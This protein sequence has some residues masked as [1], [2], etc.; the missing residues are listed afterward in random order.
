M[1][2]QNSIKTTIQTL[3]NQAGVYQYFDKNDKLLC[4]GKAKNL[5]NR[6]KS[7]W[8]FTPELHPNPKLGLRILRMLQQ[9]VRLEYIVVESEADALIL[10]NSLIKQLNPKYNILLRDDK[11]YPYIYIDEL[12]DF[13]RFELTRKVIK[14][15]KITYYG[16]FPNG[17]K[18]LLDTLYELFPLV[19]KKSC[20]REKEAC[21]FYQINKCLAPCE[22]KVTKEEYQK[23]VLQVKRA[24]VKRSALIEQLTDKM[25]EFA[26]SE[27]YEEAAT[28]RDNIKTLEALT[29]SSNIDLAKDEDLDIFAIVNGETKGVIVKLFMRGGRVISSSV[30]TFR[31]SELYDENEAYKQAL[32]EFYSVDTPQISKHIL[33]A[34]SFE[35][36]DKIAAL[37]SERFSKKIKILHPKRG[38]KA[39]L[40]A[41]AIEN[42]REVLKHDKQ[43]EEIEPKIA[44]LFKLTQTP[45]RVETFDNSHMMGVATVGAMVV[46]SEGRWSKKDYRRYAL[47]A[48]DEYAQMREM[49]TRRIES[50]EKNPPPDLWI[51]D[52]G[53]TL[54]KLAI[55]LLKEAKITLDV[56]AIAKEKLD[57]K[58]HRAKG[59]AKDIIYTKE[60][61]FELSP[62]DKRLQWVQK[63][64]DE[65][66]RF[67]IAYHQNQKRKADIQNSLLQKRGIGPATVKK[68]LNYFGTFEAIQNASYNEI[69]VAFSEKIA[70]ILT[71]NKVK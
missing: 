63:Q 13:P 15:K 54:R 7:Y 62:N 5:K 44:E 42:V 56:I 33:V 26:M 2:K 30:S 61:V 3:P 34:H 18:V 47:K 23:I 69:S 12:Q 55:S 29:I 40:I 46:W 31:N 8:R 38:S 70:K 24:I 60:S 37:L 11:T 17:A 52:G 58:A 68:L 20:L 1:N 45:Y 41:L 22:G 59:A 32:L 50:F 35:D 49:L 28:L 71:T 25:M 36:Q 21:L 53:E 14:G 65:A 6:V 43:K 48:K 66:H 57:A 64:R 10:E 39:K 9:A 51:L 19:Q 16:P 27:R 67:A 4:V